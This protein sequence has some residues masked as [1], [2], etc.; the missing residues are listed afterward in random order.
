MI[1]IPHLILSHTVIITQSTTTTMRCLL[2]WPIIIMVGFVVEKMMCDLIRI[3]YIK[4]CGVVGAQ[5]E[6]RKIPRE[7]LKKK[8][9]L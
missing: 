9:K 1:I 2:A 7:N 4:V 8:I 5:K 6:K 3:F